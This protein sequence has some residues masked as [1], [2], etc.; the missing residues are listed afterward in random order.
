MT[1]GN[2]ASIYRAYLHQAVKSWRRQMC[3]IN[4]LFIILFPSLTIYSTFPGQRVLAA[5][6]ATNLVIKDSHHRQNVTYLT[7]FGDEPN[8]WQIN[9]LT[10]ICFKKV[11]FSF[12]TFPCLSTS[13]PLWKPSALMETNNYELYLCIS[14]VHLIIL[15]RQWSGSSGLTDFL[16]CFWSRFIFISHL[17]ETQELGE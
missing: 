8:F 11:I 2:V 10:L 14:F 7:G 4:V 15:Y 12:N 9:A 6:A 1:W 5:P 13:N 3:L 16:H 17:R